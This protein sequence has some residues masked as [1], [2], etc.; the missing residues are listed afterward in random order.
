MKS[1]S[2]QSARP[3]ALSHTHQDISRRARELWEGYGRPTGRDEEIWLE[4]ERQLLGVD[5]SVEGRN[6]VSVSAKSFDK[7]TTQDK[8]RSRLGKSEPVKS[9][10]A[11][12]APAKSKPAGGLATTTRG[13]R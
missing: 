2:V 9:A 5:P 12:A 6:G 11:K 10:K 3:R 1:P 13:R 8:P 4:A 7:A